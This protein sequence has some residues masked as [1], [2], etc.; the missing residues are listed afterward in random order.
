VNFLAP[1]AL[2]EWLAADRSAN[3]VVNV[4]SI[5]QAPIDFRDIEL[6]AD[7]DG[8]TA[9]GRSKL[10]LIAWTLDFAARNPDIPV[11][12]VHPGTF[13]GTKLARE[14]GVAPQASVESGAE[15]VEAVAELTVGG[16]TSGN[17]FDRGRCV[18]SIRRTTPRF[19]PGCATWPRSS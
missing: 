6:Q 17:F 13:L 14:I 12:A 10:A 15:V 9:Y 18:R 11:N 5:G 8:F 16:E 19:R 1:F 3:A 2:T 4:A 7:Y